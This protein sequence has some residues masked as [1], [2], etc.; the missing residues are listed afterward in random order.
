MPES[1]LVHSRERERV[2]ILDRDT[3][4]LMAVPSESREAARELL[5]AP[6][7]PL[8]PGPWDPGE[9]SDSG[10]LGVMVLDGLLTRN[11]DVAGTRSREILGAND[12][13]RPWDD[14]SALDPLPS[15]TTW[16]VIEPVRLV[17][18]D[19]RFKQ[20]VARWPQLGDEIV[21]RT[22]RRSRWL[23]VL[24]AIAN[25]R[26][27]ESRLLLLLWHLAGNWGRVTPAGTLV[28]YALTHE[29]MAE[30]IGSRRPSVTTALT[31]MEREGKLE[32]VEDGWLLHAGPPGPAG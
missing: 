30:L 25:L 27:V 11:V 17:V 20:L 31:Q 28:P 32:R 6:A 26:G 21:H 13:V 15:E 9:L 23:A 3:T 7:I 18:L 29:L 22:L 16:S 10:A 8:G 12:I 14:D 4:L 2:R 24:L 19:N 1:Q 5:V